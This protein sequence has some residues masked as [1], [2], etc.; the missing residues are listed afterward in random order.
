MDA[1]V[2]IA[3]LCEFAKQLPDTVNFEIVLFDGEEALF[4][5]WD[6]SR[7]TNNLSGSI[8][9]AYTHSPDEYQAVYLLDLWT[10][11]IGKQTIRNNSYATEPDLAHKYYYRLHRNNKLLYYDEPVFY[12]NVVNTITQDDSYFFK[13]LGY[14]VVD[15]IPLPFP[16]THHTELDTADSINWDFVKVLTGVLYKTILDLHA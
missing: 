8:H 7:N 10:G 1:A 13:K 16:G 5:P 3:V 6:M 11:T 9:W 2:C 15:L 12:S 4:G 14:T